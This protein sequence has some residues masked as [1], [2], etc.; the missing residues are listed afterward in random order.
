M[1]WKNYNPNM[2]KLEAKNKNSNQPN[3]IQGL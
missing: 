2:T 3:P 1:S